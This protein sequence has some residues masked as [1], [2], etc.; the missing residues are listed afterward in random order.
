MNSSMTANAPVRRIKGD[1]NAKTM[2]G[3][4]IPEQGAL[5][6][7]NTEGHPG[8]PEEAVKDFKRIYLAIDAFRKLHKRLPTKAELRER[9]KLLVDGAPLTEQDF[10]NPDYPFSEHPSALRGES[11]GWSDYAMQ[12]SV[13]RPDGSAMEAFPTPGKLDIWMYSDLTARF[14]A[15]VYQDGSQDAHFSGVFVVLFSDGSIRQFKHKE[16]FFVKCADGIPGPQHSFP[17]TSFHLGIAYDWEHSPLAT[18]NEVYRVS[19]AE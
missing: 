16:T 10:H 15:K 9:S 4:P 2:D 12:I 14:N 19:Y 1:P 17:G 8:D 7:P 18:P 3:R 13:R 5:V 6:Y 11:M